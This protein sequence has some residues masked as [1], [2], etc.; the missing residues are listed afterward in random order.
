MAGKVNKKE[1]GFACYLI[2]EDGRAVP[3]DELTPEQL[4]RF[5]ERATQRLSERMSD[6][7]TQHP[8]EFDR[9]EESRGGETDAGR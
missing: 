9:L 5:R 7:Y 1:L 6:Y 3:W 2:L 4:R 8:E